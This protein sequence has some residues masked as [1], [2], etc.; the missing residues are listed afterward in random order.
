MRLLSE[1][2]VKEVCLLGQN[3]NSYAFVAG[4]EVAA[5]SSS[6]PL[7]PPHPLASPSLSSSQQQLPLSLEAATDP[8]ASL[9]APGF[10]TRYSPAPRRAG[11]VSFASLLRRVASI[12]PE[13]RIR[14]TS[15]HPKDFPTEVL[16][17]IAE[18]P[19]V[20]CSLHMPA[21]SGSDTVL[22]RSAFC[23]HFYCYFSPFPPPLA[24][25]DG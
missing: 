21:Q 3:V 10:S 7:S 17:T 24:L 18:L 2:G 23:P 6:P 9:Y 13:M 14:F 5:P 4:S 25:V 15:P 12:D 11:A 8:L 22:S 20:C 16:S 19:N 1:A